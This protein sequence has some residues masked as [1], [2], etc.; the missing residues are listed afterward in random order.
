MKVDLNKLAAKLAKMDNPEA[1]NEDIVAA[2]TTLGNLGIELRSVNLV[3][4]LHIFLAIYQR[5]GRN[6]K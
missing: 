3:E 1:R 4:A 2:K 6:S 5:A